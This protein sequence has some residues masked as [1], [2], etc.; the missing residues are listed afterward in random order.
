MESAFKD[1]HIRNV[2]RLHLTRNAI[3]PR[4][5][6]S[7]N[8]NGRDGATR[9]YM[10]DYFD[11]L[12]CRPVKWDDNDYRVCFGLNQPPDDV[13]PTASHYLTLLSFDEEIPNPFEDLS[14]SKGGLSD[15]PFL[16]II[17]VTVI[18]DKASGAAQKLT[19][20]DIR[21]FLYYFRKNQSTKP[22][23]VWYTQTG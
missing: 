18:P 11:K 8:W 14:D 5:N 20:G 21:E 15:M 7:D 17:L 16:S 23:E 22:I 12:I 6:V 4:N 2:W 10:F 13:P 19:E 1:L 9:F 3:M